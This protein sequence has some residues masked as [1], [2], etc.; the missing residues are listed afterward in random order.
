MKDATILVMGHCG[1]LGRDLIARFEANRY[2]VI[3]LDCHEI[4]IT[5][6]PQVDAAIGDHGPQ[7]VINCAAYTAVDKAEAEPELA[8]AVNLTGPENLAKACMHVGVPLIHISTDYVFDGKAT[9]PYRE[10]DPVNPLNVYGRSK[11]EGE[12]AVRTRLPAHLI[13]RTAWLYGVHGNSFVKTIMRLAMEREELQIVAD[14]H[15]SPTWTEDLSG[16]LLEMSMR[17]LRDPRDVPWGTYH[18]CNSGRTTWFDFA[19][20]IVEAARPRGEVKVKRLVP[21]ASADY[22]VATPRPA[23]SVLDCTKIARNFGITPRPWEEAFAGMLD[24]M[25]LRE[26]V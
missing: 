24:A 21:I 15:G 18:Y 26:G 22:P 23:F 13:V 19:R 14:Q 5:R 16:A 4:D 1:M 10:D 8:F 2:T 7:L 6:A 25:K 20:L 12:Q 11:R 9:R 3:G 17:V